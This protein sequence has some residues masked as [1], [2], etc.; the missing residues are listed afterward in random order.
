MKTNLS[1]LHRKLKTPALAIEKMKIGRQSSTTVALCYISTIAQ[2]KLV[3]QIREKLKKIDIDA[4]IDTHYLQPFLE[5]HP[6]SMFHQT[7][8]SEKPDVV[9]AKMLEGR[10]A[11]IVD[12]S[13][14]VLTAPFIMIEDFQSSNDYYKR[15]PFVSVLRILR[16]AA[17]LIAVL[18]P[19]L[20]V[21]LQ[22]YHFNVIPVRFLITLMNALKGIPLTALPEV[23]FVLLLFEVIREASV[24]MPSAVGMAMSIVG[25]L[26]LGETAVSAGMISSPSVMII[27]IS[28]I[29]VYTVPNQ[30]GTISLLRV[31]F[32]ILGGIAGLYGLIIGTLFIATTL[33]NMDSFG[34]PYLA[35]ISP[36]IFEDLKDSIYMQSQLSR[37]DR[38]RSIPN[39]NKTRKGQEKK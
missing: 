37:T 4:I 26:V 11:V 27:A 19:G 29:A 17:I 36:L 13:P 32:T 12:G 7:G 15:S 35:P 1:L 9:A 6:Y 8:M 31:F 38:P 5:A 22:V 34:T 21:A 10:V 2:P 25:A 20:Y 3:N 39:I 33:V 23:L 24:R 16:F 28:S 18:L 30:V 14:L